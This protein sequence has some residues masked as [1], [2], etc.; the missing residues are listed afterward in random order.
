ME[1]VE[2]LLAGSLETAKTVLEGDVSTVYDEEEEA[3]IP[4]VTA[5]TA[6]T[7]LI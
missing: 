2:V 5:D 7:V 1:I 4:V 3:P 6:S